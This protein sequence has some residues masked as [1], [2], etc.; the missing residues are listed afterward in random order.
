MTDGSP[1]DRAAAR[2]LAQVVRWPGTCTAQCATASHPSCRPLSPGERRR[3]LARLLNSAPLQAT[4]GLH[5]GRSRAFQFLTETLSHAVAHRSSHFSGIRAV[6]GATGASARAPQERRPAVAACRASARDGSQLS[7]IQLSF[8]SGVTPSH[9]GPGT[10]LSEAVAG[11]AQELE[12]NRFRLDDGGCKA[13]IG[14]A[15][16]QEEKA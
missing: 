4:A 6:A 7:R 2:R 8:R 1:A 12:H 14:I 13:G 15:G 16:K 10:S 3:I 5:A 9:H 11:S